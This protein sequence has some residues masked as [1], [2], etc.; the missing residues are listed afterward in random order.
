MAHPLDIYLLNQI[1]GASPERMQIMLLSRAAILVKELMIAL[2]DTKW[3]LANT[4]TTKIA[5]I[6][7]HLVHYLAPN[8]SDL[9]KNLL[10]IYMLWNSILF[11]PTDPEQ[12]SKLGAMATHMMELADTW[13]QYLLKVSTEVKTFTV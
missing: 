10:S 5:N 2:N 11:S 12:G 4:L 6:I 8:D 9:T 13:H 1:N 3:E 7:E